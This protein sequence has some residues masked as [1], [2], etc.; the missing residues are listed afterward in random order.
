MNAATRTPS[1][2]NCGCI[3]CRACKGTGRVHAPD[4]PVTLCTRCEGSRHSRSP[5]VRRAAIFGIKV[6]LVATHAPHVPGGYVLR[7]APTWD[8]A[9]ALANRI[10]GGGR[11]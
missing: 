6:W 1:R 4:Q 2:L 3:A 7:A 9:M 8:E 5:R 10:G 11:G